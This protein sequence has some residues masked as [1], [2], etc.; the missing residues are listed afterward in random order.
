MKRYLTYDQE[1][2]SDF[3]FGTMMAFSLFLVFFGLFQQP[4]AEMLAGLAAIL[5]GPSGLISDYI[6]IGGLGSAFVNAGLVTLASTLLLRW[7]KLPFSGISVAVTFMMAGFAL[8]GKNILNIWPILGGVWIYSKYKKEDFGRFVYIGLFG[9][10]LGP[11]V[12]EMFYLSSGNPL[13]YFPAMILSGL[14]IGFVLPPV[15]AY[16]TRIHQGYNLYNVGFA[17]GMIGL[18]MVS[19]LRSFGFEFQSWMYWNTDYTFYL[20]AILLGLFAAITFCGWWWNGRSFRGVVHLTRHSGRSVADFIMM[21]GYAVTLINMGILGAFSVLVVLAVQGD[22]NGPTIGGIFAIA[23]FGAFGKHMRN[24]VPVMAGVI[25]SSCLMQWQVNE[26]SPM[27]ALLFSTGL[28]PISGQYGWKWGVAAGVLHG[29]IVLNT[30][31]LHG[32][33][34]LYNNGFAAGLVCIVLVP[35]IQAIRDE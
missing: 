24:I 12:T 28:A 20:A 9:T 30:G 7:A 18:A 8:F 5:T 31:V 2:P 17:A 1:N 35:V 33:L 4:P 13:Q 15:A 14:V 34:N 25:L 27:L 26:P 22:I 29:S 6:V 21:D 32:W 10:T 16:T 19:I 3:V 11:V 23:G